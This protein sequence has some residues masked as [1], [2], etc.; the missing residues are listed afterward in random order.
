VKVLITVAT[1]TADSIP[2]SPN[3][4]PPLVMRIITNF[5]AEADGIRS[6]DVIERLSKEV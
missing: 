3:K 1:G 2:M 6:L 5:S 4:V